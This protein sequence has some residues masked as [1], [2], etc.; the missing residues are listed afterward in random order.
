MNARVRVQITTVCL[1]LVVGLGPVLAVIALLR[2]APDPV[3]TAPASPAFGVAGLAELAVVAHVASLPGERAPPVEPAHP[4]LRTKETPLEGLSTA[5]R[6]AAARSVDIPVR[7]ASAVW[8]A[9]AGPG[10]WGVTVAILRGERVE[11]WQ[12]TIAEGANGPLLETI[13]AMVA[14]P[15][16]HS[17]PTPALS[18]LRTPDPDDQMART[19][20]RFLAA[21]LTSE[22]ELARYVAAGSS[23]R[24]PPVPLA[25]SD[26]LRIGSGAVD[27]QH[28]A[29]LAE[30]RT[31]RT[32]GAVH[33]MQ[34]P[35]LLQRA[36]DRWEVQRLLP[37]TPV[38][39]NPR[40]TR[41][42]SDDR[43]SERND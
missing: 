35:L 32:D 27:E 42:T 7:V 38:Q 24:A 34:Y 22:G 25:R 20:E 23:L 37:A 30:V 41:R 8:A 28:L 19:V 13:P 33:L 39:T 18:P 9:P 43:I 2:P 4:A 1:W 40:P 3:V 14:L 21:F 6:E 12:V 36:A 29:V 16:Q 31:V 10:R 17:V 5:D 11:G 15:S 26:L